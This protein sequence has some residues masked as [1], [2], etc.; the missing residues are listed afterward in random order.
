MNSEYYYEICDTSILQ[1]GI[2][3]DES[4][5]DEEIKFLQKLEMST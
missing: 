2:W 1:L 4:T 5:D 3:L